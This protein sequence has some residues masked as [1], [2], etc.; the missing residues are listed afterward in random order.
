[1]FMLNCID[2]LITNVPDLKLYAAF[3]SSFDSKH[4][5]IFL[6]LHNKELYS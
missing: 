6:K 3:T 5:I 1:M 2:K 4:Y